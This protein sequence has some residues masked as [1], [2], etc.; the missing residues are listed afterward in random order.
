MLTNLKLDKTDVWF[1][2]RHQIVE[3]MAIQE[4]ILGVTWSSVGYPIR[5]Q[6][7]EEIE[8]LKHVNSIISRR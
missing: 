7:R 5:S 3:G 2:A 6:F 8:R 4:S 1:Q